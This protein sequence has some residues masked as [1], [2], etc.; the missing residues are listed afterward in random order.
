[1]EHSL[2]LTFLKAKDNL[3]V[4]FDFKNYQLCNMFLTLQK[5]LVIG[6]KSYLANT[7]D[8]DGTRPRLLRHAEILHDLL[9][10]ITARH[11]DD[12]EEYPLQSVKQQNNMVEL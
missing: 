5:V 8:Q 10:R 7:Q 12:N 9:V 6:G 11:T 1:M 3:I 2:L 4:C